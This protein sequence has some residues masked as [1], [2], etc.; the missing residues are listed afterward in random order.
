[1]QSS[2]CVVIDGAWLSSS[3]ECRVALGRELTVA[4]GRGRTK[5]GFQKPRT[6]R[7]E[8]TSLTCTARTFFTSPRPQ[9]P[10]TS[11]D[12]APAP[13]SSQLGERARADV[14]DALKQYLTGGAVA[15]D[16]PGRPLPVRA[17]FNNG[18]TTRCEPSVTSGLAGAARRGWWRVIKRPEQGPAGE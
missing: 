10:I 3:V 14:V 7:R 11:Q 15:A 17:R 9:P 16:R 1:M 4:L 8:N 12:G 6:G 5:V 13:A 2:A 18:T